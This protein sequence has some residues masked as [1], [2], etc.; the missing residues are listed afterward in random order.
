MRAFEVSVNGEKVCVAGI[1]D[2]GVLTT[3][4]HW[5]AQQ[6]DEAFFLQVGGLISQRKEHTNWINQ[7]PLSVGDN[8]QVKIIETDV[9]DR[10]VEQYRLDPTS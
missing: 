3:I 9:A 2:D 7:K 8:V 1:R 4:V 10:P 5:A 6:G